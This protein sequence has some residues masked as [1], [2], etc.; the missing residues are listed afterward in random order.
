MIR[1]RTRLALQSAA[2]LGFAVL[3]LP[4]PAGAQTS[5]SAAIA[6]E[7]V[8]VMDEKKLDAI[9]AK[10]PAAS[11]QF[12]AALY[13]PG[14]Q[15]LVI[16]GQYSA[17]VLMEPRLAKKEY[18]DTYMELTGTVAPATRISVQDLGAPGLSQRRQDNLFD[19]WTQ[20]GK[21]IMFDGDPDRQKISNEDYAKSFAAA[22]EEYAKIL[23]ALLAE[24]KK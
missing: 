22:D 12:A 10:L 15:L 2:V 3:C 4:A 1:I 9:A 5:K 17:P 16:S 20:A 13:F 7:L 23:G 14:V 6:K 11:D 8:A 19:T 24:A 21:P 18:K